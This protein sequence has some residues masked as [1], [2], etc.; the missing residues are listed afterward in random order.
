MTFSIRFRLMA[1]FILVILITIGTGSFFVARATYNEVKRYDEAN[2]QQRTDRIQSILSYYYFLNGGWDDVQYLIDQLY[3]MENYP[4]VLTDSANLVIA[5]SNAE[6]VGSVYRTSQEATLLNYAGI[7][8]ETQN[9]N[10]TTVNGDSQGPP[11]TQITTITYGKLYITYPSRTLMAVFIS[12]TINKFLLWGGLLAIGIAIIITIFFSER[13][14][15]PLRALAASAKKLGKGD[16]SQRVSAKGSDEVGQLASTFNSM[17]ADLEKNERLRKNMVAD[18]AHELRTPLSNVAGYLEA[19]RDNVIPADQAT[20]ASLSEEV[21]LLTRL[22]SD[23][24]ELTLA[25][26]GE[27]K[28][29]RQSEDILQLIEQS[30]KAQQLKA[31]EKELELTAVLPET[32]PPVYIDYYRVSEVLRNL[33]ANAITHTAAGGR[34]EIVA[35]QEG[36]FVKVS[37]RDNGEGIPAEDQPKMF[38]RFY[39]VDKSRARTGGG[40]GLGLTISKR[41]IEAHGGKIGLQSEQGKGSTFYFTLP[42]DAVASAV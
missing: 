20:I 40:S 10:P 7:D 31:R 32:L 5:A 18:V 30:I 34:I 2:N 29:N 13:I 24:Q 27:L 25:D 9:R 41:L 35:E 6:L 28:L 12:S 23:L 37:V 8:L 11:P 39:R 33:V 36:D 42:V 19:I 26:S 21:D 14:S 1:S 22:V 4:I 16:F 17:A 38:E 15:K 3:A